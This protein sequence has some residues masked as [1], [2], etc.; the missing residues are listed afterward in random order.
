MAG[1]SEGLA[2]EQQSLE[3]A[4]EAVNDQL[5]STGDPTL[6]SMLAV[7]VARLED[8][9]AAVKRARKPSGK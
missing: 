6:K 7:T 8:D 1:S 5:T 9:L 2:A 4:L 3:E